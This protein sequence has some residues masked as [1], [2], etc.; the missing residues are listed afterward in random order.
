[1][2]SHSAPRKKSGLLLTVILSVIALLLI[3]AGVLSLMVFNDPNA[4]K[5]LENKTPS[6]ALGQT[7]IKSALMGQECSFGKEEI[8]GYL[9]Y[10]I[11]QQDQKGDFSVRGAAVTAMR[12]DTAELYLPVEY[13][14]KKYG[15]TVHVTPSCDSDTHQ[16]LFTV[17]SMKIGRLPVNP[18]WVL[19]WILGRL[20]EGLKTEKNQ[21]CLMNQSLYEISYAGYSAELQLKNIE[22][23]KQQLKI[24]PKVGIGLPSS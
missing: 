13:K 22:I 3:A 20:P 18:E 10:L 19:G 14:R 17:H 15:V 8:N 21:I 5:G 4:G 24:Q 23:E 7:V 9:A 2:G 1:M 12:N 6:N 11:R 16:L